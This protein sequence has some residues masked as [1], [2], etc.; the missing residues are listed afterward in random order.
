MIR[1]LNT[2]VAP[3]TGA[4]QSSVTWLVGRGRLASAL[5]LVWRAQVLGWKAE[6][7]SGEVLERE[8]ARNRAAGTVRAV[9]IE[10]EHPRRSARFNSC[11][12]RR[13]RIMRGREP[14]KDLVR[15]DKPERVPNGAVDDDAEPVS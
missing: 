11:D 15:W 4:L 13:P 9:P 6:S 1:V 7:G 5:S 12:H 2:A 8:T 3:Q 10:D 14:T